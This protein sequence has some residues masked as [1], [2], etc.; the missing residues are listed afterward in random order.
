[1]LVDL[2]PRKRAV[3][4]LRPMDWLMIGL[5]F[6]LL[7]SLVNTI[8]NFSIQNLIIHL[9]SIFC[10]VSAT[11]VAEEYKEILLDYMDLRVKRTLWDTQEG[12]EYEISKMADWFQNERDVKDE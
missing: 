3:K 6:I 7:I 11:K 10:I 12:Q 2:K 4:G 9:F 5:C 1:M 8:V